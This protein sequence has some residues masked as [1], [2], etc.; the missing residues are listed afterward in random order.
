MDGVTR[1]IAGSAAERMG[2]GA[3]SG[4]R[5]VQCMPGSPAEL[6]G[7]MQGDVILSIDDR[8]AASADDIYKVLD[9]LSIGR[10][11]R[12]KLPRRGETM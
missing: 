1:H 12:V 4:V 6:A 9:R 11:P 2:L 7:I 3:A 10:E 5:I 8:P